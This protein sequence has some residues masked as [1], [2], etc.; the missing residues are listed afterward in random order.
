MS[1]GPVA[2]IAISDLHLTLNTPSCRAEKDWLEV[3]SG[4]FQQVKDYHQQVEGI[5]YGNVVPI[6]CAGDVFDR[7]NPPIE[8]VNWAIRTL[9]TM[10]SVPGQHDL[11]HHNLSD[12]KKSAYWTLV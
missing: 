6:I 12:I 9:P 3:M 7:P 1:F 2:A 8:L 5:P 11:V 4:Y 10:Y